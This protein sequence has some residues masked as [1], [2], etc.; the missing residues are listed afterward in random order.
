MSYPEE[1]RI[2]KAK[3]RLREKMSFEYFKALPEYKNLSK[4]DYGT[5]IDHIE[6]FVFLILDSCIQ[7]NEK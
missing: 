6:L 2:E 3:K 4:E 1:H 5:L 7:T